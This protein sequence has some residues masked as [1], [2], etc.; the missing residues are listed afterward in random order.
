MAKKERRKAMKKIFFALFVF[1]FLSSC[2]V[3]RYGRPVGLVAPAP[4]YVT[5]GSYYAPPA[6]VIAPPVYIPWWGGYRGGHGGGHHGHR[7]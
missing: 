1:L 4:I 2:A 6:Y 7:Y 5:P 3:D